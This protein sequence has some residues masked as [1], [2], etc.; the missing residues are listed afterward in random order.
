MHVTR[1]ARRSYFAFEVDAQV[2]FNF[3]GLDG[4][5]RRDDIR[6]AIW[7]GALRGKSCRAGRQGAAR[8][9]ASPVPA[10]QEKRG[11]H[12]RLLAPRLFNLI[13][14]ALACP[15]SL[16]D[17]PLAQ[18]SPVG[19]GGLLAHGLKLQNAR[20]QLHPLLLQLLAEQKR[21]MKFRSRPSTGKGLQIGALRLV[22]KTVKRGQRFFGPRHIERSPLQGQRAL[23]LQALAEAEHGRKCKTESHVSYAESAMSFSSESA[24][25]AASSGGCVRKF[26][27]AGIRAM[28]R[29]RSGSLP[30][31]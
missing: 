13:T 9:A 16:K 4:N 31:E 29:S 6:P 24:I 23:P 22:D 11:I 20:L 18:R 25:V 1:Q 21:K 5:R 10:L 19:F 2:G 3:S 15:Q 30:F 12:F 27:N 8:S 7:P 17:L 14:S 26:R 28:A